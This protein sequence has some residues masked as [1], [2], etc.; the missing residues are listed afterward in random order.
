[1]RAIRITPN[2]LSPTLLTIQRFNLVWQKALGT[3]AL[4]VEIDGLYTDAFFYVIDAD[5][6]YNA[7]LGWP[8][9]YTSKAI[10]YT[11]HQCFKYTEEHGSEKIIREEANPFHMEDVNYADDK[12]YKSADSGTS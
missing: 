7:L 12:F 10:A 3:I 11:L 1:V 2:Q 9:F 4:K 8:W 5:T 6:S